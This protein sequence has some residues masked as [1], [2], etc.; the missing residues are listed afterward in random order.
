MTLKLEPFNN[1]VFPLVFEIFPPFML[2][3]LFLLAHPIP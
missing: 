3:L 2:F 1:L